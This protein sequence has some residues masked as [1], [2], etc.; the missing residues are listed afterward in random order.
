MAHFPTTPAFTGFNT[1][2]RIEADILDLCALKEDSPAL[3]M[4]PVTLE[5]SHVRRCARPPR[6]RGIQAHLQL[7]LPQSDP[8]SRE[9]APQA[10][11]L[12]VRVD[13]LDHLNIVTGDLVVPAA[14]L[15]QIFVLDPNGVLLE[16]DFFG[17]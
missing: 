1:P 16:L 7:S 17:A 6:E 8:R 15:R 3:L 10:R 14:G 13:A 12:S 11:Q 9:R 2:T 5:T 4:N